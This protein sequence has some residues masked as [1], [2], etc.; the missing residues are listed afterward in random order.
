LQQL[1]ARKAFVLLRDDDQR[2]VA[3]VQ[4]RCKDNAPTGVTSHNFASCCDIAE[5]NLDS[6]FLS[7]R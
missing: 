5:A 1:A 4:R 6:L 7:T 3:L 2:F